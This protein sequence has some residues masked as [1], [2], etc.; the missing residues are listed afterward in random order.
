MFNAEIPDSLIREGSRSLKN[1]RDSSAN[2][3]VTARDRT[4][5]PSRKCQIRTKKS[6]FLRLVDLR[7]QLR[8]GPLSAPPGTAHQK[9]LYV[10]GV[11]AA[12]KVRARNDQKYSMSVML[13]NFGILP[14]AVQTRWRTR[15]LLHVSQLCCLNM[16]S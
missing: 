7:L 4:W 9:I 8:T 5:N 15:A 12:Y 16:G 13:S 14:F 11:A 2:E 6:T 3:A 10:G 1:A